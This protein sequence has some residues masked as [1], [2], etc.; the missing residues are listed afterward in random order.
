MLEFALVLPLLML[1]VVG[2]MDLG[3]FFA[4]RTLLDTGAARG[5]NEAQKVPNFDTDTRNLSPTSVE[6]R[7][8]VIARDMAAKAA[9]ALPLST[10]LTDPS[11][12]SDSELSKVTT[13][14][15]GL[16]LG[17]GGSPPSVVSGAAVL[18]PG[19]CADID[20]FG[21]TCNRDWLNIPDSDP[22]PALNVPLGTLLENHPVKVLLRAKLAPFLPFLGPIQIE[23]SAMGFREQ[24]PPGS[25]K[26]R[27]DPDIYYGSSQAAPSST[28]VPESDVPAPTP[29]ATYSCPIDWAKC[30]KKYA[31][32]I[33]KIP[34]QPGNTLDPADG[35]CICDPMRSGGSL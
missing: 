12:P 24:L 9:E 33:P 31:F 27:I 20:G 18:R 7:R 26:A 19:E 34:Y 2:L 11:T 10:L 23:G 29:T 16:A 4:V 3:R 15:N 17:P 32:L 30:I 6:Y 21:R 5:L 25:F 22:G 14:D 1:L 8:F 28:E 13:T 35:K